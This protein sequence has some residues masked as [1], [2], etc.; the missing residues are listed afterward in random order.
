MRRHTPL[1]PPDGFSL[2][3]VLVVMSILAILL[4]AGAGALG[5]GL[6]TQKARGAAQSWQAAS[7][8]AQVGV[9][10]QGGATRV[11]YDGCVLTLSHEFGLC[12]GD[13]GSSPPAVGVESN[14]A[15]W[16]RGAGVQVSYSGALASPDG[17]GSLFFA[18][19]GAGYRVVVRPVSGMTVRS[20]VEP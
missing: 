15:R 11:S 8:W 18:E 16:D 6:G 2:V 7:A 14:V 3:E 19:S 17:G 12:G 4:A 1:I 20:L 5:A 13:L 10:Y 9:L